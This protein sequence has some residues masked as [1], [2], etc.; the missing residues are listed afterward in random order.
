MSTSAL[1][2]LRITTAPL[3]ALDILKGLAEP[4]QQL[5]K[6]ASDPYRPELHYARG[7][8]PKWHDS[9][10]HAVRASRQGRGRIPR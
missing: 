5:M 2:S 6:R 4:W 7:R 3:A 1:S 9:H 8:G 10:G